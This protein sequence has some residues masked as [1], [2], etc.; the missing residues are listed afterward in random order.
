MILVPE[1]FAHGY[2]TLEIESELIYFHTEF[3]YPG[4]EAGL[5]FDDPKLGIQLPFEPIV[6]SDKDKVH[7]L[8]DNQFTG[9]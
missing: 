7:P 1:G 4:H 9:I 8:I 5:R 6:I 2:I 3:Y